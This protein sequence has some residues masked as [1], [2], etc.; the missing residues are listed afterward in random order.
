MKKVI[1]FFF[2]VF[3]PCILLAQADSLLSILD[4]AIL[5]RATYNTQRE[6]RIDSLKSLV[7]SENN[8]DQRYSLMQRVFREYRSY[9]MDS[10]LAVAQVKLELSKRS[11]SIQNVYESEMNIAEI[12]GIMGM[13]KESLEILDK[14][15][16]QKLDTTQKAFYFHLHHSLYT[17]LA[18]NM[19]AIDSEKYRY[20][21]ILSHYRDSLI[22]YNK[23]GTVGFS[24]A[25]AGKL[26]ENKKY[27][28]AIETLQKIFLENKEQLS[29]LAISAY[30]LSE[31]YRKKGDVENEKKYLIIS[32][33]ADIKRASK[34]YVSLIK[35]AVLLYKEGDVE[36]AYNYIK[37]ATED[38][39]YSKAR[40]RT[41]QI[42]EALPIIIATYDEKMKMEKANLFKYLVLISLLSVVLI[43]S[44]A[45][46]YKQMKKLSNARREV[47]RV[48]E[49]LKVMNSELSQ[50]ND[51][52]SESNR[53]KEEYIGFIFNLCSDY[54]D[55]MENYRKEIHRKLLAGKTA[56]AS[57]LTGSTSLVV[58]E[59][60]EFFRNFDAIFLTIFPNFVEEF[61]KLLLDGEKIYPKP[62]DLLSPE[63]RV[64]ALVRLGITESSKIAN[65]LHYS[66]Q[67]VYN[68]NLKVRNKLAV[69]KEDF[70]EIIQQIGK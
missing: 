27:D 3:Y 68:Y 17:R 31:V 10:A 42:S 64:F 57:K 53:I 41:L 44:L 18:D 65:F 4:L 8:N 28:E 1:V 26:V 58:D 25:Q 14:T 30:E 63:L 60:K 50:L 23:Q 29:V 15:E 19:I 40:F 7:R 49:D 21:K 12:L 69:S 35:L 61:N 48:L 55:K 9:H 16:F 52:L 46:I 20:D 67:T 62:G 45:F 70:S 6:V 56:E 43:L 5:N 37:C 13:Y 32:S 51:K 34:T 33:I 39:S 66:P 36:R 47:N 24:F 11:C 38:A 54:I 59:L 22:Q 2:L